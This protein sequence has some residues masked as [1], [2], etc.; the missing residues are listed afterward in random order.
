MPLELHYPLDECAVAQLGDRREAFEKWFA[1]LE[2][3]HIKRGT[4][5][6][7]ILAKTT[8]VA[9]WIGFF[10]DDYSPAEAIAKDLSN[11]GDA[12]IE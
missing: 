1:Q 4:P 10:E 7:D 8:G 9:S 11:G 12:R 6:G 3:E 2:A 5:Y